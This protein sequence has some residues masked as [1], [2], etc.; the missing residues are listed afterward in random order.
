MASIRSGARKVICIGRQ[1]I[2]PIITTPTSNI[3]QA[4][5]KQTKPLT[6]TGRN[7]ADHITE[8]KNIR[9]KQPFFFLKPP[10]SILPPG[11][12]PVLAPKGVLMHFEVELGCIIGKSV[13]DLDA[14]DEQ[15]AIDAIDGK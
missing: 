14:G 10:S 9:P 1:V 3:N 8:L 13:R 15:G 11:A 5:N 2:K 4:P 7:Y 6:S 12:G